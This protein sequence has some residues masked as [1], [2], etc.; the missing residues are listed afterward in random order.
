MSRNEL[1]YTVFPLFASEKISL[2]NG[3][4]LM[5]VS[6]MLGSVWKLLKER[7]PSAYRHTKSS[8]SWSI[9]GGKEWACIIVL[10][11]IVLFGL[12]GSFWRNERGID[13]V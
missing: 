5:L 8:N 2:M 6:S 13:F 3:R 4:K 10:C 12:C 11:E 7:V 1:Q 9:V